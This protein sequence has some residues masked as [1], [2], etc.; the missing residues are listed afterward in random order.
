MY[1]YL[2]GRLKEL[3]EA[4]EEQ[5]RLRGQGFKDAFVVAFEGEKRITIKEAMQKL[6]H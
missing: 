4:L 6:K 1:K 5:N 3:H 2:T